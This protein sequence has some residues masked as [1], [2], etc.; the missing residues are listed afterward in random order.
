GGAGPR[1]SAPVLAGLGGTP[2]PTLPPGLSPPGGIPTPATP[3]VPPLFPAGGGGPA[4]V[5]PVLPPLTATVGGVGGLRVP[6]PSIG[7]IGGQLPQAAVPVG[8]PVPPVPGVLQPV[9]SPGPAAASPAAG[10]GT[11]PMMPP[12]MIGGIGTPG[13]GAAGTGAAAVRRPTTGRGRGPAA[14]PGLP[15]MLSGRAGRADASAFPAR[16]RTPGVRRRPEPPPATGLVDDDLWWVERPD[17]AGPLRA[18]RPPRR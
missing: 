1:G 9:S 13:G 8:N 11:P 4:S 7:G 5:A 17:P 2:A 15:A 16:P 18:G 10:T 3:L 14:V 12:P 6:G